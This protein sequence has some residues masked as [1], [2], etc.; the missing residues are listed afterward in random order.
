MPDLRG[1]LTG[2]Q[3][4]VRLAAD[5]TL[6]WVYGKDVYRE[7]VTPGSALRPSLNPDVKGL[8][9]DVQNNPAL[10]IV[11]DNQCQC[12]L[13]WKDVVRHQRAQ[14]R[15]V[16]ASED[17]KARRHAELRLRFSRYDGYL[18][19]D[20]KGD[21]NA[22]RAWY[23]GADDDA[24]AKQLMCG[25]L[26][27]S[28]EDLKI[29]QRNAEQGIGLDGDGILVGTSEEVAAALEERTRREAARRAREQQA[30]EA[31]PAQREAKRAEMEQQA[32]EADPA[33]RMMVWLKMKTIG[34][35]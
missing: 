32:R 3:L 35:C 4:L 6:Q 34:I 19:P 31:D 21:A 15:Q 7:D 13:H 23:N 2:G 17:T 10:C 25:F 14:G 28:L 9:R 18:P 12:I 24:V 20:Y 8:R 5:E 22:Y 27:A 29:A 33:Q 30:R 26:A 1:K 16:K 11:K